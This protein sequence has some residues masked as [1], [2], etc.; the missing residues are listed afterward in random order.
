M[1]PILIDTPHCGLGDLI[2]NIWCRHSA[3]A[4]GMEVKLSPRDNLDLVHAFGVTPDDLSLDPG[5]RHYAKP[6]QRTGD[7]FQEM[8]LTHGRTEL[9]R[10]DAWC[11]FRGLGRLKPVRPP[12]CEHPSMGQWAEQAWEWADGGSASRRVILFPHSSSFDRDWPKAYWIDLAHALAKEG[13]H[14]L[15]L[16]P[17]NASVRGFPKGINGQPVERVLALIARAHAV[18]ANDSGGAHFAG[19]IGRPTLAI[20]GAAK[21]S[22]VFAH[23]SD[24]VEWVA[25]ARSLVP[26]VGCHFSPQHGWRAAC[27]EA[28]QALLRLAPDEVEKRF[29]DLWKRRGPQAGSG[30]RTASGNG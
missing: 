8:R 10:F 24:V 18:V 21:G 25:V 9:S 12:Y 1:K 16:V 3:K 14:T 27:F 23:M 15:A 28:C 6:R 4:A 11:A 26:C 22:V 2:V 7:W 19:T 5:P 17:G 30:A 13:F 20:C 29:L